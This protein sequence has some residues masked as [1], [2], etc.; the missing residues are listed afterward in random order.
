MAAWLEPPTER[1]RKPRIPMALPAQV[2]GRDG[3]GAYFEANHNTT[4]LKDLS[5]NGLRLSLKHHVEVG[6][7]LFILFPVAVGLLSGAA[8][9]ETSSVHPASPPCIAV[10]GIVR[11][12]QTQA[13]EG[14]HVGVEIVRHRFIYEA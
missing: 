2:R 4:Q 10:T 12:C 8:W 3:S 5:S 7:R 14:C 9:F 13:D 6:Q 1:R 11:R